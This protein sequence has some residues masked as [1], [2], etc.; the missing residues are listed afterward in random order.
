[1]IP[2]WGFVI[3]GGAVGFMVLNYFYPQQDNLTFYMLVAAVVL[4]GISVF[5]LFTKR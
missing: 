4:S 3:I 2:L 1:M 5:L